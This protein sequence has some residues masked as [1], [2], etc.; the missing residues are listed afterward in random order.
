MPD[1][2]FIIF[3]LI[4]YLLFILCFA[5]ARRHGT[6]SMVRL[7]SASVFGL[8]LELGTLWGLNAYHYGRFIVMV[9]NVPLCIGLAW[10]SIIYSVM[11]FSDATNLP[12]W[13]RSLLDGL[14][15]LNIDLS[16]DAVAI[17]LG[18]W[19]WG[20][21]LDFQ[22]LGVPYGNFLAWFG[23]AASFSLGCRLL[24]HHKRWYSTWL[25]G[26]LGLVFGLIVVL[27]TSAFMAIILPIEYHGL[28]TIL[29][30][31]L[32]LLF[33]ISQQPRFIR[34]PAAFSFFVPFLILLYVVGA[35]FASG[36]FHKTREL[37]D[38]SIAMLAILSFLHWSTLHHIF[39]FR[40]G[41][42][43]QRSH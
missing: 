41:L 15:A 24:A 38:I 22:Y 2:Y 37:S 23:M 39:T 10:G 36:I 7:L 35:G 32:A 8:L 28:L 14:L 3:E 40:S 6:A 16:L 20:Q 42:H 12:V 33:I 19:D 21:G 43:E 4:L 18:F 5:H 27:V 17:R 26:P 13:A 30:L 11:E 9:L 1:L 29:I 25:A 31:V 34:P